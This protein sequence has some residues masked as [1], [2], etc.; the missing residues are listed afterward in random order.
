MYEFF[1]EIFQSRLKSDKQ[2][3]VRVR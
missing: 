1:N 3:Q 2:E